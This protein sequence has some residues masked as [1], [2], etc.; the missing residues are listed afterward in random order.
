MKLEYRLYELKGTVQHYAWG[1]CQH[2][3]EEPLP[4]IAELLGEESSI[5]LPY[6]ELWLGAHPKGPS[7]V[8]LPDGDSQ[9]LTSLITENPDFWLGKKLVEGGIEEL[10]FLLKILDSAKPLSIQA[11]PDRETAVK[12]HARDPQNYPDPNHKPEIAIA[13]EPGMKALCGFRP[14]F[15]IRNDLFR[16]EPLRQFFGLPHEDNDQRWLAHAY[17]RLLTDDIR[18][19][20]NLLK[21]ID[22]T[23]AGL[24]PKEKTSQDIWFSKLSLDYPEDRGCLSVYFMNIID[25]ALGQALF[26][27][28]NQPHAYLQ[29][30]I[31]ECMA[32]SDNVVRAGLTGKFI[33]TGA[34]LEMLSFKSG[35]PSVMTGAEEGSGR[36]IYRGDASEFQVEILE[37]GAGDHISLDSGGSISI[38]LVLEGEV[39]FELTGK[40]GEDMAAGR[41]TAWLWP[42]SLSGIRVVPMNKPYKVVR[43]RPRFI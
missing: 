2:S 30:T 34:L 29:G 13:L 17:H 18:E 22:G 15:E 8:V 31:V 39:R 12:L 43:A 27:G 10:P 36:R 24:R 26:L 16:L 33:D 40:K 21:A 5:D 7:R 28:P 19:I 37:G 41:G 4:F 38:L 6:A 35:T 32:N 20:S 9:S 11:H 42:G 23:L 25:L 3:V 14:V 1:A